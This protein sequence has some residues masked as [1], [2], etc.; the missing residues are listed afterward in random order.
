MKNKAQ[1]EAAAIGTPMPDDLCLIAVADSG[2]SRGHLYGAGLKTA[3]LRAESSRALFRRGLVPIG[4]CRGLVVQMPN[5][6]CYGEWGLLFRASP[7][8][9][10]ST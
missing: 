7:L 5:G 2:M 10:M 8:V 9:L 6:G 1:E 4:P 3:Y